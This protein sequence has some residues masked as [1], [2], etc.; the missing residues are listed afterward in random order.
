MHIVHSF[1]ENTV[2]RSVSQKYIKGGRD[3]R[4]L[5]LRGVTARKVQTPISKFWLPRTSP[6]TNA[7]DFA[8][9]IAQVIIDVSDKR[10]AQRLSQ[11]PV[12]V[13]ADHDDLLNTVL[14]QL[15]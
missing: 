5:F 7:A 3:S 10:L 12:M 11:A 6:K 8:T 9:A 4:P 1:V 14:F 13:T 2:R 15:T